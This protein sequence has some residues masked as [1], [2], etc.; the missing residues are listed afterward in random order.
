MPALAYLLWGKHKRVLSAFEKY[1]HLPVRD[2]DGTILGVVD[3]MELVSSTAGGENGSKGWRDFFNG[4]MVDGADTDSLG[5]SQ[6]GSKVGS[7]KVNHAI[8]SLQVVK[9]ELC[10]NECDSEE[11]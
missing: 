11:L 4:G 5:S 6:R 9:D 3:V 10:G 8:N 1:L 7:N 2:D